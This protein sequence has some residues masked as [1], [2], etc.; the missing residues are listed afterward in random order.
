LGGLLTSTI[1]ACTLLVLFM[2]YAGHAL[3]VKPRKGSN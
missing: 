1:V 3:D 2:R